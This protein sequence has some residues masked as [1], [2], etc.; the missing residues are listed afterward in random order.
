MKLIMEKTDDIFI[1][2]T[3]F[4]AK[5]SSHGHNSV[6]S[7]HKGVDLFNRRMLLF[8]VHQE[9]RAH[10]CLVVANI[11]N[12]E[13]ISFDS[14]NKDNSVCLQVLKNYLQELNGQLHFSVMQ[15]RNIPLQS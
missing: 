12:K 7:W 13:I 6:L 8:P 2:S 14:L 1:F 11:P 3:F 10:W 15:A 5:L 4:Y 9:E